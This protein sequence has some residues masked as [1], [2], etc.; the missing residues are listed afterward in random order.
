MSI[1]QRISFSGKIVLFVCVSVLAGA[2][3]GAYPAVAHPSPEGFEAADEDHADDAPRAEDVD[4]MDE[5]S[6][7]SFA[8]HARIHLRSREVGRPLASLDLSSRGHGGK[9]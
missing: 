2:F 8:E 5:E 7:R 9:G 3:F 4:R 1:V 6:M